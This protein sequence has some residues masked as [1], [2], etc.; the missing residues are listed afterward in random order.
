MVPALKKAVNRAPFLFFGLGFLCQLLLYWPGVMQPDAQCQYAAAV[1][2]HY[3]D[4]HPAF[5]SFVWRYL[6][7]IYPGPGLL[8]ALNTFL[9]H[10]AA[11][12]FFRGFKKDPQ[13]WTFLLMPWIPGIMVYGA[14]IYKDIAFAY[15]FLFC[16]ALLTKASLSNKTFTFWETGLFFLVL[17]YGTSVKFQA[18]YL[19]PLFLAWYVHL[20]TRGK[21]KSLRARAIAFLGV[22]GLFWGS[23]IGVNTILVPDQQKDHSWQWVKLYDLAALS[24]ANDTNFI[25]QANQGTSFSMERMRGEFIHQT[26]NPLVYGSNPT[27]IKGQNDQERSQLWQKWALTVLK[28]PLDYLRHRLFNS[29]FTLGGKAGFS[30]MNDFLRAHIPDN[31]P[32]FQIT[33]KAA[34][35]FFFIFLSAAPSLIL[36]G[37]YAYVAFKTRRHRPEATPLLYMLSVAFGM[38]LLLF[39]LSLAG[40][41]RYVIVTMCLIHASHL[42]G[43]RCFQTWRA[44]KVSTT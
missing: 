41:P 10:G 25:P 19:A 9:L 38:V 39:F 16:A 18:Q 3:S 8:L 42:M 5:M 12:L 30:E 40:L 32:A 28:H 22:V 13:A 15:S 29:A 14:A 35:I 6:D 34:Y 43:W 21:L 24:L 17:F 2:G 1:A 31:T 20:Q 36:A 26:I 23:L 44:L 11:F 4:H 37:F 27:L 33:F 7:V